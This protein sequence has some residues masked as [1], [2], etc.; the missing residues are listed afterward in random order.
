MSFTGCAIDDRTPTR[1]GRGATGVIGAIRTGWRRWWLPWVPLLL[2]P[3]LLIGPALARGEALFWGTP[4]L[5]FTPWRTYARQLLAAG[6]LPLWNPALG[7]GAPLLANYQTA[8]LYPPNWILVLLNV[9]WGQTVLVMLHLMLAAI[10]M[11]L[12][13]RQLSLN[14]FAQAISGLAFGLSG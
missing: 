4:I 9:A 8:L 2:G 1:P 11:A 3:L 12:L 6:Q 13:A 14:R 7:M 5:Q 10:G